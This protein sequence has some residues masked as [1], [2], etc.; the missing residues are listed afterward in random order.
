MADWSMS[1]DTNAVAMN[2]GRDSARVALGSIDVVLSRSRV[3]AGERTGREVPGR[4]GAGSNGRKGSLR[5]LV[6]A[7]GLGEGSK[8]ANVAEKLDAGGRPRGLGVRA[9][10]WSAHTKH[11][12]GVRFGSSL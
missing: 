10:D 7:L 8:R 4:G 3:P 5:G 1:D 2:A 12:R 9:S 11:S 6:D